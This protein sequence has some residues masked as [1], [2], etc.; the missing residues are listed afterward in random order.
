M[1]ARSVPALRED[2]SAT[3]ATFDSS[4]TSSA[5][6]NGASTG[7]TTAIRTQRLASPNSTRSP[8]LARN[9][10][11]ERSTISGP[12]ASASS[13]G[14]SASALEPSIS[15]VSR[16]TGTRALRSTSTAA[17][18]IAGIVTGAAPPGR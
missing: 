18:P 6:R 4:A 11:P 13:A 15:P 9:A 10:S 2:L 3:K 1:A 7:A 12:G 8:A 14:S 5:R 17:G 16:A